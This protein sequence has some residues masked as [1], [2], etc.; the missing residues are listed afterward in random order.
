MGVSIVPP[1]YGKNRDPKTGLLAVQVEFLDWLFGTDREGTQAS[2]CR[3]RG[4]PENAPSRWKKEDLA[5]QRAQNARLR[6]VGLGAED[7][8]A[9]IRGLQR[10]AAG[11]D[12]QSA[13]ALLA[14]MKFL[15]PQGVQDNQERSVSAL[16]DAEIEIELRAE[17]ERADAARAE[18][19]PAVIED[20]GD[21]EPTGYDQ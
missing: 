3:E 11:G 21:R 6:D 8:A 2:W 12:P 4:I 20:P 7:L 16:S 14:W 15:S 1:I 9:T 13:N 10:K 18:I 19:T 5:F 17:L